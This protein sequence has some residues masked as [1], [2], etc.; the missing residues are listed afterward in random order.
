[1]SVTAVVGAQWGDEGKGRIIDYLAQRAEMVV[2]FQG[3][4]NA[5]HTIVNDYGKNVLHLVPSGIFY[6]SVTN[7]IGSGCVVNPQSLLEE[8][9][10]LELIGVDTENLWISSRAHMVLPYHRLLDELEE[11]EADAS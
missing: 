4:D 11:T 7:V 10:H 3:G 5:G 6:P 9:A 1:M 8:L 2:R